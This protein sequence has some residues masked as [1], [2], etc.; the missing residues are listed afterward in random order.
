MNINFKLNI[1]FSSSLFSEKGINCFY[2]FFRNQNRIN[3]RL[4]CVLAQSGKKGYFHFSGALSE[5]TVAS[6]VAYYCRREDKKTKSF[7]TKSISFRSNGFEYQ[8]YSCV[9]SSFSNLTD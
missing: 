6:L 7:S 2:A 5:K 8:Y 1:F 9:L 4:L 3:K